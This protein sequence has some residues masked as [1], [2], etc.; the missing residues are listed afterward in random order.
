M[1]S[2]G[3]ALSSK[4]RHSQRS[5]E[6]VKWKGMVIRSLVIRVGMENRARDGTCVR[7]SDR[8]LHAGGL[9][10]AAAL[11][12]PWG[13]TWSLLLLLLGRLLVVRPLLAG[14][15]LGRWLAACRHMAAC[16]TQHTCV[17]NM[18]AVGLQGSGGLSSSRDKAAAEWNRGL[19]RRVE[20]EGH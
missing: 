9:A 15:T 16:V 13:G 4:R 12:S 14:G 20:L 6:G 5:E 3:P 19:S 18:K 1:A 11:R 10:L 8:H 17:I 2:L 7:V